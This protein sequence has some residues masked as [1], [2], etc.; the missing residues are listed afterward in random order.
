MCR[1]F[2]WLVNIGVCKLLIHVLTHGFAIQ[3]V[4]DFS[5]TEISIR[6]ITLLVLAAGF[7]G[8]GLF[9]GLHCTM[10]D[11]HTPNIEPINFTHRTLSGNNSSALFLF[12]P[13]PFLTPPFPSPHPPV[14]SA[15]LLFVLVLL[16]T[17]L[18]LNWYECYH[19]DQ[20]GIFFRYRKTKTVKF[21]LSTCKASEL[22]FNLPTSSYQSV[23]TATE[24]CQRVCFRQLSLNPSRKS[25]CYI[26][27]DA[28]TEWRQ[29]RERKQLFLQTFWVRGYFSRHTG[30][31]SW[32]CHLS[33]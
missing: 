20:K 29:D 26:S 7:E 21:L 10:S 11:Q 25:K 9:W 12:F 30:A 6:P 16:L 8:S 17:R 14:S 3:I 33:P 2:H 27:T 1:K 31:N 15:L 24:A 23:L 13:V 5:V 4:I 19:E 18:V 28:Q 22:R 32:D